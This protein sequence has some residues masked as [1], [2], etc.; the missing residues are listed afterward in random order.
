MA[1][2]N[3]LN[4]DMLDVGRHVYMQN[5]MNP[6]ARATSVVYARKDNTVY[7]YDY[8]NPSNTMEVEFEVRQKF[9]FFGHGLVVDAIVHQITGEVLWLNPITNEMELP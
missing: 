6:E 7:L 9:G 5:V 8:Q 1:Q 2:G 4:I 3:L